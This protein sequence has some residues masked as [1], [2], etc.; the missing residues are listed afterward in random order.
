MTAAS[1]GS[2]IARNAQ[3][4]RRLTGGMLAGSGARPHRDEGPAR[5]RGT[6]PRGS[7]GGGLRETHGPG[8]RVVDLLDGLD[9]QL[10]AE[11]LVDQVVPRRRDPLRDSAIASRIERPCASRHDGRTAT[12]NDAVTAGTS[13]RRPVKITRWATLWAEAHCSR[14]SRR[15]PSPTISR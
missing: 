4:L 14:K 2:A 11:P 3:R 1:T 15:E 10:D 8:A 5:Q 6:E 13:S 12:S 7:A 9:H